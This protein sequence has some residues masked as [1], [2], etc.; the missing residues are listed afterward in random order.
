MTTIMPTLICTWPKQLS[1]PG[2]NFP[3]YQITLSHK[4]SGVEKRVK[5]QFVTF[6]SH[7]NLIHT[8]VTTTVEYL[9]PEERDGAPDW[10]ALAQLSNDEENNSRR[11]PGTPLPPIS[12]RSATVRI[13]LVE[14]LDWFASPCCTRLSRYLLAPWRQAYCE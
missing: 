12:N 6:D 4:A 10:L 9:S 2:S 5:E 1:C 8:Y 7:S 11:C 14:S 13:I 3:N